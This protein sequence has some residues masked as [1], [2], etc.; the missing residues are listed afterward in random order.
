[1]Y[2]HITKLRVKTAEKPVSNPLK[3]W[4]H[5]STETEEGRAFTL[6]FFLVSF[7]ELEAVE[8]TIDFAALEEKKNLPYW[9][10]K[11]CRFVL[12]IVCDYP[13]EKGGLDIPD[14]LYEETKQTGDWYDNDYG[15]GYSPDYEDPVFIEAH[16]S[17][18]KRVGEHYNA[19]PALAWIELGS[20]GHWGEWHVDDEAGIAPF[21][22]QDVTN[23]YAAHYISAFP[24][25]KLLLRRPYAIGAAHGFGLY[26]DAFGEKI[27]H[28]EWLGWIDEGYTA[29]ET[30][31][32]LG[33]MPDFWK[34][35]PS[36]GEFATSNTV[37][38]YFD[39]GYEEV[40]RLVADGHTTFIGPNSPADLY[41]E[42]VSGEVNAAIDELSGAL[43][44][45]FSLTNCVVRQPFS[46]EPLELEIR[47]G[48]IGNAPIYENWKLEV[49]LEDI[50]GAE[51][52]RK[53]FDASIDT[54]MPG[55]IR[56][57]LTLTGTQRLAKGPYTLYLSIIDPATGLPGIRFA[58]EGETEDGR[59][60]IGN[61][62]V[63]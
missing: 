17:L 19:D 44:Y 61:F 50:A 11:G 31:E 28:E 33:G 46:D 49:T 27:S 23:R 10:E 29:Y 14:W 12:R 57:F 42:D 5:W 4:V 13:D 36:G 56:S 8:G 39:E 43:G 37:P 7:R 41:P 26:N 3:G 58:N 34:V 20:L 35:A 53:R 47:L 2:R 15:K 63:R 6:V 24:D 55:S 52:Y 60:R 18:L 22:K 59:Y 30:G 25:K 54:W 16:R 32:T 40:V 51:A 21:P 62:R 1:M 38:Y 9:R 48:N 45:C